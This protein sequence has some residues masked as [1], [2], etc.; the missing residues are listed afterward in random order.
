[1]VPPRPL[2]TQKPI[3]TIFETISDAASSIPGFIHGGLS[4][5]SGYGQAF[6]DE[7]A[8][9]PQPHPQPPQ[10]IAKKPETQQSLPQLDSETLEFF[11]KRP[12]LLKNRGKK[13]HFSPEFSSGMTTA[14]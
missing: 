7:A 9:P 14:F 5:L 2:K 10:D 8:F 11:R 4:T 12:Y 6:N 1:M 3:K 13:E